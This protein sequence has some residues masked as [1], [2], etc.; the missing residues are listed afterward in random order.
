MEAVHPISGTFARMREI[1]D[2][3]TSSERKAAEYIMQNADEV[4]H[5][6]ITDLAQKSE[7]SESTIV[8]LCKK[9]RLKGY[10]ELRVVLAQELASPVKQIHAQVDLQDSTEETMRKVFQAAR[11]ALADTESLNQTEQ[12]E[13]AVETIRGATSI[14]FFGIGA[15]GVI[16]TD[17]YYRFSK[18]GIGCHVATDGHS[19]ANKA[20]LLGEGDVVIGI[21]HSGRTRDVLRA[22]HTAKLGG[23]RTIAITQFGH[24][25]ITDLA[26]VVLFTSS[27]E[28]A[29]RTEAMAS[30]IA[31]SALLDTLFVSVALTR[32][33]Q[34]IRNYDK[35]RE[36]TTDMRIDHIRDLQ[37]RN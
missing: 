20:I 35:A 14:S 33:E 21:S 4:I 2:D 36:G 26:D 5:L 9:L 28:T 12:L 37:R 10:Q 32:Y 19:Q 24:S 3:L 23:A 8:R 27:M 6:S 30:R 7:S 34:V 13:H 31:Q 29:F 25:P 15:S 18:L 1:A 16:A 17:A 11:Q 22:L